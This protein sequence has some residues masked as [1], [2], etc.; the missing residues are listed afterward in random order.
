MLDLFTSVKRL[1][2]PSTIRL[3]LGLHSF[4]RNGQV[5]DGREA[6]VLDVVLRTTQRGDLDGVIR[7]ID[8]FASDRSFLVNVG[9][10]KGLIL[11]AAI[12]R[13]NPQLLVELGAY[14]GYS[15]LRTAR[16]MPADAHLYSVELVAANAEITRTML[17]HAG[18]SDR[19]TVING[20]IGDPA[21]ME[22]LDA[23][24]GSGKLDFV[25]IDHTKTYYLPDLKAILA[26]GWLHPASVVVA[27][28]VKSPG[29]PD[30]LAHLRAAEGTT[31]HTVEHATHVEYLSL[32]K[33]LVL[34]STYLG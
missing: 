29:A 21:T 8:D 15:A 13:A 28:N 17:E 33:D 9:N 26:A 5:G 32:I 11:D 24:V 22:K 1:I 6:A 16:V 7:A 31:W 20:K 23:A 34:E 30:Y 14:V 27:D 12:K 4:V 18:V 25:F 3:F 10:E 19:V 2:R